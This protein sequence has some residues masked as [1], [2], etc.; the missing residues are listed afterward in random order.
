[1]TP[2]QDAKV[3]ELRAA[4]WEPAPAHVAPPMDRRV[5]GPVLL[6]RR[7]PPADRSEFGSQEWEHTTVLPSGATAAVPEGTT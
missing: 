5:G 4:G 7:V 2:A 1:M 3:K 6:R